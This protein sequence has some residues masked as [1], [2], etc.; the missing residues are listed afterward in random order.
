MLALSLGERVDRTGAF[1]S[2][3]GPGEGVLS[4][5]HSFACLPYSYLR[6]VFSSKNR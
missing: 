2:R 4:L 3:G 6:H 5:R 1:L